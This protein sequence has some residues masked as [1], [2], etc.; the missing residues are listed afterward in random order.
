MNEEYLQRAL[1]KV[2]NKNLLI[3]MATKRAAQLATVGYKKLVSTLESESHLN[4][5]LLEIAE[6]K[7]FFTTNEG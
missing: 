7:V 4:T 2:G 5:A 6:G 1:E 3:N